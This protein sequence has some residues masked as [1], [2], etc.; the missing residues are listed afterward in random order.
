MLQIGEWEDMERVNHNWQ[1]ES[2]WMYSE[3]VR[4]L[5]KPYSLQL[6]RP[7]RLPTIA[8]HVEETIKATDQL[9]AHRPDITDA[10]SFHDWFCIIKFE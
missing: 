9:G 7:C 5:R 4:H 1:G 3:S 6:H 8:N 10:A 2:G